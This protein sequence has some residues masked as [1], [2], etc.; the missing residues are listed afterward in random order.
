MADGFR[1]MLVLPSS[2]EFDV[3]QGWVARIFVKSTGDL[4][5][6][7]SIRAKLGAQPVEL[8]TVDPDGSGFSGYLTAQ[9]AEGDE[10]TVEFAGHEPFSTGLTFSSD[11]GPIA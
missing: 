4:I 6:A 9:P 7:Q 11:P 5:G 3:P 1:R 8:L 2:E 10:L